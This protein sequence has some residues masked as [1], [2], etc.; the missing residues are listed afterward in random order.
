MKIQTLVKIMLRNIFVTTSFLL[1]CQYEIS[2]LAATYT[3]SELKNE[4][5]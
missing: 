5:E 2:L 3:F 1:Q 4:Q